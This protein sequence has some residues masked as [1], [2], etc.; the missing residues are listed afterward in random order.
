MIVF[1]LVL[2]MLVLSEHVAVAVGLMVV[3]LPTRLHARV[4]TPDIKTTAEAK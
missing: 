4:L 3:Y 2:F 1:L